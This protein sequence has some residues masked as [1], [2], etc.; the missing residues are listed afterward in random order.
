MESLSITL[1]HDLS[2]E[3]VR[4]KKFLDNTNI[5]YIEIFSD[6]DANWYLPFIFIGGGHYRING[7]EEIKKT[8]VDELKKYKKEF[9][10]SLIY[11]RNII[12]SESEMW[13]LESLFSEDVVITAL[14]DFNK[15]VS[16]ELINHLFDKSEMIFF[17]DKNKTVLTSSKSEL[18][19]LHFSDLSEVKKDSLLIDFTLKQLEEAKEKGIAKLK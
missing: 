7:I 4:V 14:L 16:A 17:A 2:S 13:L 11:D 9:Y 18:F 10:S 6:S 5:S 3:S 12:S 19:S 15:K 8:L 1:Y